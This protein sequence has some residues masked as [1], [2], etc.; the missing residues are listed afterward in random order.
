MK[1]PNFVPH[2]EYYR[3]GNAEIV[4]VPRCAAP[5]KNRE[6]DEVVVAIREAVGGAYRISHYR[7]EF[8]KLT[9]SGYYWF[10]AYFLATPTDR[11]RFL[12]DGDLWRGRILLKEKMT[13]IH[14]RCAE[15]I[16]RLESQ[17]VPSDDELLPLRTYGRDFFSGQ[18]IVKL[19][20]MVG[21]ETIAK[22]KSD[23]SFVLSEYSAALR[24]CARGLS[25]RNAVRKALVDRKYYDALRA[26]QANSSL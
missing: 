21:G 22:I 1:V 26:A 5:A 18:N 19:E 17:T 14:P 13:S 2:K 11:K 12:V 10:I 20:R 25:P 7:K 15:G 6:H 16:R 23:E 9:D 3:D 4:F 24:W 8:C